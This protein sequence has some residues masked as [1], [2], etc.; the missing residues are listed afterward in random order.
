[1]KLTIDMESRATIDL[2]KHGVYNY[3]GHENT[4]ILCLAFKSS[5][6]GQVFLWAPEKYAKYYNKDTVPKKFLNSLIKRADEIEAHNINFERVM[7][8]FQMHKKYGFEKLPFNKLRCSAALTAVFALPRRLED[9]C[10]VLNLSAQKDMQGHKIMQKMCKPRLPL[11]DEKIADPLYKDHIY[12]HEKSEFF[13]DLFE[14]CKKDVLAEEAL[15]NYL[16]P[17]IPS[18][19]E[20]F[21]YN[22]RINDRGIPVDTKTVANLICK[23]EEKQK[24]INHELSKLTDGFIASVNQT[25]ALMEYLKCEGYKMPNLQKETI[26]KHIEHEQMSSKIQSI[27]KLRQQGVKSSVKKFKAFENMASK[28]GRFRG[29]LVYHGASTGRWTAKGVQT[30][31]LPRACLPEKFINVVSQL[32]ISAIESVHD[33]MIKTASQCI[34]GVIKAGQDN[35]FYCADFK[36][37]EARVLGWLANDDKMLAAFRSGQDLY[38]LT[39]AE[40]Y[41][42]PYEYIKDDERLIG[43][44]AVLALGYKGW[45]GAFQ[46]MAPVYG[47]YV[48]DD[49]AGEI[50][51][52]WREAHPKIVSYWRGIEYAAKEVVKNIRLVSSYGRV[53]FGMRD[54]FLCCR[55]PSGRFIYWFRPK[56]ETV[57][58]YGKKQEVISYWGIHSKTKKWNKE[59]LHAGRITQNIDQAISRDILAA[60]IINCED[61]GYAVV[62]HTHDEILAEVKKNEKDFKNF[63]NLVSQNPDWAADLPIDAK[64]WIGQRYKK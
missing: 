9:A 47:V 52:K 16:H 12:W 55:L 19:L 23:I 10:K 1:M 51:G 3:A 61:N 34:R 63:I 5:E 8:Y 36:S 35:E 31:N 14:Y 18:E 21:K 20:I 6:S 4:D 60:A 45:I 59:Y 43:K 11:K 54:D 39:A 29:G 62:L 25:G 49:Q 7:W 2:I 64:G 53:K 50:A 30:Q 44:V 22:M 42:K 46:S 15:A 28:D 27:L 37:I 24:A 26:K 13:S 56:M 58:I 17:L 48:P 32:S 57:S 41:N 33:C 38:K 40:I